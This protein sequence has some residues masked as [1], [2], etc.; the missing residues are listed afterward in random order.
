M[1]KLSI[2]ATTV[3]LSF[4]ASSFAAGTAPAPA[5]A[6]NGAASAIKAA[7]QVTNALMFQVDPYIQQYMNT[8]AAAQA[9]RATT[10]N[11]AS[12]DTQNSVSE[13]LNQMQTFAGTSTSKIPDYTLILNSLTSELPGSDT[14]E[15]G[16]KVAPPVPLGPTTN[17]S[18]DKQIQP[19]DASLNFNNLF[20][21]TNL[22]QNSSDADRFI[23]LVGKTYKPIMSANFQ[24]SF[25]EFIK[26]QAAAKN[27]KPGQINPLNSVPAFAQYQA[28]LRS[29]VAQKSIGLSN[30]Y[31]LFEER[32]PQKALGG[33]SALQQEQQMYTGRINNKAWYQSL[34]SASPATLAREQTIMLAEIEAELFQQHRTEERLLATASARLLQ[35][36]E[37]DKTMLSTDEVQLTGDM[38]NANK[39]AQ[40][41]IDKQNKNFNDET[42]QQYQQ[43]Q[44]Q[45]QQEK[46]QKAK[47]KA[48]QSRN[49]KRNKEEQKRN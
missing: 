18:T 17:A 5:G 15:L 22:G 21:Q 10:T 23:N 3:L 12:I 33:A 24:K 38:K 14:I 28:D 4:G 30:L 37:L 1:K 32:A 13:L 44:K 46:T 42:E 29:Y 16:K 43:Q 27:K 49:E 6:T 25:A 20:S 11:T 19:A 9:A 2:V 48:K 40:Q 35:G 34:K 39:Q 8:D 26:K 45:K 31:Q 36:A 47:Q 41:Q 7:N